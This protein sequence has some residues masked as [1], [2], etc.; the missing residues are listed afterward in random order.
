MILMSV[1]VSIIVPVYNVEKKIE[2]C[3]ESIC[4]QTLKD[5][6]I[7]LVNDGSTDNSGVLCDQYA[8]RD[9]RIRVIHK[10]NEGLVSARQLGVKLAQGDYIGFVDSDDWIERN[11]FL[12]LWSLAVGNDADIVI[13][14]MIEDIEGDCIERRNELAS[15]VYKSNEQRMYFYERM[16]NCADY[17]CLGIQ[18]YLWNKLFKRQLVLR[19]IPN[20]DKRIRVGEDAAA[21]FPMMLMAECIVVTDTCS[22]HYCLHRESMM[23]G[24]RNEEQEFDNVVL[25]HNFL[26]KEFIKIHMES[27]TITQLERYTMS[28]LLARALGK[29]SCYYTETLIFPY[30]DISSEQKVILYG[31][32]AIGKSIYSYISSNLKVHLKYWVDQNAEIYQKLGF[33]VV[34]LEDILIHKHDKIIIAI[35]NKAVMNGIKKNL[36]EKGANEQQ[37]IWISEHEICLN[38]FIG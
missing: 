6:E 8:N 18:P 4:S 36:I 22:Y 38:N 3:I 12:A 33:P 5:I 19:H 27:I 30:R 21:T 2:R 32:G 11:M 29:V 25:L 20:I 17:F 13:E 35:L 1:L 23:L 34:P 28:N 15:G 37:I 26:K 16:I 7:I 9:N 10:L 31:A 24:K 14:G